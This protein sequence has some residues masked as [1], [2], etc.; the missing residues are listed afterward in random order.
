MPEAEPEAEP[1][2]V[3]I[4]DVVVISSTES[5]TEMSTPAHCIFKDCPC[6]DV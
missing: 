6:K 4:P 3:V 2:V 1:E 5:E